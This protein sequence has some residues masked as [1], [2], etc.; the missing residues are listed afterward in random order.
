MN[1]PR[2]H[3][4]GPR[5]PRIHRIYRVHR[6]HRAGTQGWAL[7]TVFRGTDVSDWRGGRGV[8]GRGVHVR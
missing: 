8:G 6:I 5:I 1:V 7:T 2:I 3:L 4:E